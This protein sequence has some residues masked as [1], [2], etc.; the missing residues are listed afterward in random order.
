MS[1]NYK[2]VE[3]ESLSAVARAMGITVSTL[4]YRHKVLGLELDKVLEH[5]PKSLIPAMRGRG[6]G[7]K[8]KMDELKD[9]KEE[10]EKLNK[11]LEQKNKELQ[12]KSKGLEEKIAKLEGVIRTPTPRAQLVVGAITLATEKGRDVT[13]RWL[14]KAHDISIEAEL[15]SFEA[16]VRLKHDDGRLTPA[17]KTYIEKIKTELE[18]RKTGRF[19][20]DDKKPDYSFANSRVSKEFENLHANHS[21]RGLR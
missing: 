20:K 2:G 14:K 18:R 3:Y 7:K 21:P 16:A 13:D 19:A 5:K 8:S 6:N 1:Y 15:R 4:R 11:E 10:L 9:E 17:E 12:Q